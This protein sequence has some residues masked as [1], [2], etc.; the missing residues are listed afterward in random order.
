VCSC[1]TGYV[2]RSVFEIKIAIRSALD[3]LI[4][5]GFQKYWPNINIKNVH[6]GLE[7]TFVFQS[8]QCLKEQLFIICK[9]QLK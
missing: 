8:L 4:F 6:V 9:Y 7:D 1:D 2:L 3:V 5:K